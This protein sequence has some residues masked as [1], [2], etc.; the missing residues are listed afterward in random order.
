MGYKKGAK[1]GLRKIMAKTS[2]REA[3][4][5]KMTLVGRSRDQI[6]QPDNIF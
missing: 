1:H 3:T 6:P 5:D 2:E 4:K